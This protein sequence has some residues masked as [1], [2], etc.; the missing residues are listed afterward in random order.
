MCGPEGQAE[1]YQAQQVGGEDPARPQEAG[2]SS[3]NQ[4]PG[5]AELYPALPTV[6][7]LPGH[8]RA[9]EIC[10]ISGCGI[11]VYYKAGDVAE[12]ANH[13]P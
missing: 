1:I 12:L 11:K 4:R 7:A 9:L 8:S 6:S 13:P 10:L 2:E 5:P 3:G